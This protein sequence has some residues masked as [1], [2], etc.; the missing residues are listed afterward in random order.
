MAVYWNL[1]LLANTE[2]EAAACAEFFARQELF[3]GALRVPLDVSRGKGPEGWL[4]SVWPRGMSYGSPMGNDPRLTA[5]DARLEIAGRFDAWLCDAPP[6]KAAYF[7]GEA[8][9]RF[10]D[11]PVSEIVGVEGLVVDEPT[12]VSLGRPIEAQSFHAGRYWW[13]RSRAP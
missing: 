12:W 7:G 2:E 13:R 10:L 5:D 8:F 11:E 4:V 1:G 6:F 9:D 3:L